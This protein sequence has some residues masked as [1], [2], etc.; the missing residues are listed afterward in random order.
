MLRVWPLG[1][2]RV[3]I[4]TEV[5]HLLSDVRKELQ[6][7]N[8]STWRTATVRRQGSDV[9]PEEKGPAIVLFAFQYRRLPMQ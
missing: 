4:L 1:V 5:R 2:N 7:V 8:Q 9:D 6:R 3:L